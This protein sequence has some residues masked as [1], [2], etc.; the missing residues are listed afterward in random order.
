M[1]NYFALY[2]YLAA[3]LNIII[4]ALNM[5]IIILKIL[6]IYY[7]SFNKDIALHHALL[8]SLFYVHQMKD[9]LQICNKIL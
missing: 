3:N 8:F 2:M 7:N 4:M 9:N 6:N 5:C 1:Y